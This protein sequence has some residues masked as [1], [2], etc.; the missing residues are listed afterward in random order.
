MINAARKP[1]ISADSH[2]VEPPEVW[3]R[4]DRKF[5]ELGPAIRW[6]DARQGWFFQV[7]GTVDKRIAQSWP[8]GQ[9]DMDLVALGRT[10]FADTERKGAF[11]P[12][13][14]LTEML[15]DD[16]VAEVLYPTLGMSI[17]QIPDVALQIACCR[18]YNSWLSEFC[19]VAPDR[20]I[21][22]AVISL[23]DPAEAVQELKRSSKTGLRTMMLSASQ[24][25]GPRLFDAELD[26]FWATAEDLCMPVGF[27]NA[28]GGSS[29]DA[30]IHRNQ[31]R[32]A[33][34][35]PRVDPMRMI[36]ASTC[37]MDIQKSLIEMVW[38]GVL[39]RHPKLQLVGAEAEVGWAPYMVQ[40]AD[41]MYKHF[42][43][44]QP[45]PLKNLPSLLWNENVWL[46]FID[47]AFGVK[48]L[49][50]LNADRIM[51]SNDYPHLA[52][53]WP[54]SRKVIERDTAHLSDSVVEKITCENVSRLYGIDYASLQS[55]NL[56]DM[57]A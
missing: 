44:R 9:K 34:K 55:R 23:E 20:L 25:T 24:T 48:S 6:D 43:G 49:D 32:V 22:V 52:S 53:T 28:A 38:S 11:D 54:N 31:A 29:A 2:T 35:T 51:W 46:T 26:E 10:G 15:K 42:H 16:V 56:L 3:Q 27:H 14:R 57:A 1:L 30:A 37:H 21:G 45:L 47:D 17:F 12:K 18:A 39:E 40:V 4:V 36:Y 33:P 5:G 41:L 19:S 7:G 13:V 50:S 8:A